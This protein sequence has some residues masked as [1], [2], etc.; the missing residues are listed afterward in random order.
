MVDLDTWKE[1]GNRDDR[2]PRTR[3][4]SNKKDACQFVDTTK[5][6]ME[7]RMAKVMNKKS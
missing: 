6:K 2:R 7:E 5:G 3:A 1:G 4:K